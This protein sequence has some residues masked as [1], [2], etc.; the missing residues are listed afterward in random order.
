M[1]SVTKRSTLMRALECS[2][3]LPQEIINSIN[4]DFDRALQNIEECY[5]RK[6]IPAC[7]A[8]LSV[9]DRCPITQK[10][11]QTPLAYEE[12]FLIPYYEEEALLEWIQEN[13][14]RLPPQWPPTIPYPSRLSL[15]PIRNY[16]VNSLIFEQQ[17]YPICRELLGKLQASSSMTTTSS[18]NTS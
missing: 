10:P 13:P 8:S 12:T 14:T 16:K 18:T 9:F 17:V 5:R 3:T 4:D 7:L 2:E 11:I 1:L 15:R 6:E